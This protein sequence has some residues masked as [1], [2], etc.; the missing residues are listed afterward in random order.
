MITDRLNRIAVA[1]E[2]SM[3]ELSG[4]LAECGDSGEREVLVRSFESKRAALGSVLLARDRVRRPGV[5]GVGNRRS[6]GN[7][8][9]AQVAALLQRL[10]DEEARRAVTAAIKSLRSGMRE[11]ENRASRRL[12][13]A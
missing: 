5:Y 11:N 10:S 3:T 13:F 4:R 8:A 1:I 2:R 6:D 12:P 9:S 7:D